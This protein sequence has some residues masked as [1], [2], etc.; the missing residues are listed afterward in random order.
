[1]KPFGAIP[2]GCESIAQRRSEHCRQVNLA[3][4]FPRQL[5]GARTALRPELGA[6]IC[7]ADAR[8]WHV[9]C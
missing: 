3:S 7:V 9:D 5:A 1:M 4:F 8:F 6:A 2:Y